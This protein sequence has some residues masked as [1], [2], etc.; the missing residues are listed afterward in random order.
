MTVTASVTVVEKSYVV[1]AV[2]AALSSWSDCKSGQCFC[3]FVS[4][5]TAQKNSWCRFKAFCRLLF[6]STHTHFIHSIH[7]IRR[8][9][10]LVVPSMV[11]LTF[12]RSGKKNGA[13]VRFDELRREFITMVHWGFDVWNNICTVGLLDIFTTSIFSVI[14]Y[15]RTVK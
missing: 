2:K 1:K 12:S 15:G 6:G 11:L 3:L 14:I 10:P 4:A 8:T 5:P 7:K 13:S 9:S